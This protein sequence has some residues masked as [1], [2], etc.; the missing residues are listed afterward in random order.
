MIF[1][2][3]ILIFLFWVEK[4]YFYIADKYNIIDK[5]NER[6]LHTKIT[7]RGGG[8]IFPLSAF[9]YLFYYGMQ[10]PYF[11]I[12]L[13]LISL[14][15]FLD[16]IYSLPNKYRIIVQLLS[17]SL[18]LNE[19]AIYNQT[20][21][22]IILSI[23]V[24]VGIINAY[25]FMDGV[26]GITGGYSLINLLSLLLVNNYSVKFI[27]DDF[28]IFVSLGLFVFNFFNFRK[29]AKCFAGDVGSISIAFIIVFLLVKLI[30][31]ENQYIYILFLTLYGIDTIFTLL[32]RLWQR[33]NIFEAH[34]K[35]FFQL[36][37]ERRAFSHLQVSIIYM[38][39]QLVVNL[40]TIYIVNAKLSG[41]SFS[42]V[43]L[44]LLSCIYIYGRK[45]VTEPSIT[46]K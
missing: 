13:F 5:P 34:K 31:L 1:Y 17:V 25:N 40:M 29:Q 35:H 2:F 33:E 14:I 15:S 39:L 7:I 22:R 19:V 41:L 10:Y 37:V 45:K 32:I 24:L 4:L 46:I 16:D 27:E 9:L 23:I 8:I 42:I 44:I 21:F 26:N 3:Y 36:L 18:L 6:S 28:V 30:L 11:S 43:I 38:G 12:G 20:G